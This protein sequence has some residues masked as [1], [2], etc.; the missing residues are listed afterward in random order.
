MA[1]Y[2]L[3]RRRRSLLAEMAVA[4]GGKEMVRSL[5]DSSHLCSRDKFFHD[6]AIVGDDK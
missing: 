5:A 3:Q 2:Q 4:G 1:G 6:S